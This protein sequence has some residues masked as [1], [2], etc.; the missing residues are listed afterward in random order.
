MENEVTVSSTTETDFGWE[1]EVS[2]D[3]HMY[4]VT[5]TNDYYFQLTSGDITPKE[6][7]ERSF[8]FLL[9]REPASSILSE[10]DLKQINTYFPEYEGEIVKL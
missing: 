1:F 10:F 6:L 8:E 9:A 4:L 5:L 2:I 7:V 3:N